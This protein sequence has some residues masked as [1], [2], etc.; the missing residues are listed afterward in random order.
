MS[1]AHSAAVT[2]TPVTYPPFRIQARMVGL[3]F[4]LSAM[5]YF[6]RA[7]RVSKWSVLRGLHVLRHSY[8]SALANRGVDQRIIDELAGHQTEQQRRRY[9]HLYQQTL[10]EAVKGVFG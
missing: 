9:R 3:M 2:S 7:L 10:S 8:I 5:N 1:S 6:D 4:A